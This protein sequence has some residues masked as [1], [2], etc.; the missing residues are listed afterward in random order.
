MKNRDKITIIGVPASPYTR[1][2]LAVLRFKNIDYSVIWGNPNQILDSMGLKVP[3]PTLL[4]VMILNKN[5]NDQAVCDSTPIIRELDAIYKQRN[6]IPENK[7]LAFLNS[8]L[9]DFGDE[10]VTKYMF[11]YRWHFKDDIEN[12][13]NIL[14]LLH[15]VNID[16]KSHK[17]FKK[18]ISELQISRLWV[19][20][21]NKKT[22]PII[23]RSYKRFLSLLDN[24]FESLPF[25][26]GD[27]PSSSDFAF[28]L[29]NL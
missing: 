12:A 27:R 7:A 5:E 10:W 8:I 11:H 28:Y 29:L 23:E 9:E 20:G 17:D 13:G 2:M 26:L 1:K 24:H 18:Y 4:P 19:V 14:P 21:S 25:L 22:A 15:S 6:I 3:K 16:K